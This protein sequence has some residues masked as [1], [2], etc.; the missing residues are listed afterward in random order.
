MMLLDV[1]VEQV[2][3]TLAR[4]DQFLFAEDVRI[5]ALAEAMTGVWIH[6][7]GAVA[8]V[9]QIVHGIAA[10]EWNNYQHTTGTFDGNPVSVAR[11]DQL[12]VPGYCVFLGRAGPRSG[13]RRQLSPTAHV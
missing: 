5:E 9:A 12:G 2:S 1:P 3:A 8:V 11:I 13:S 4:L 10:S 7:P 6:G